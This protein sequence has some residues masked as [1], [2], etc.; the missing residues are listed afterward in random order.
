MSPTY[1]S[2]HI[3]DVVI[4]RDCEDLVHDLEVSDMISDHNLVLCRLLHKKPKPQRVTITTRKRRS[5]D[6]EIVKRHIAALAVPSDQDTSIVDYYNQSLTQILDHHAPEKTKT[7]TLHPS[8][9]WFTD[10]LH[11]AKVERRKAERTWRRTRLTVHMEIF[12][13]AKTRYNTMLDQAQHQYFNEKLT[14]CGT[15]TRAANRIMNEIMHCKREVKRPTHSCPRELP[16]IFG[17]F[18]DAKIACIRSSFPVIPHAD[19]YHVPACIPSMTNFPLAT[20][21]EI[22]RIVAKSPT[23]GCSLD[24]MPT[25]MIKAVLDPLLPLMVHAINRSLTTGTVPESMKIARVSPLLKKASLDCEVLKNYRPVS[26]LSFLS[27]I[28]EKVVASRLR[29]YMDRHKLHDPMQ[30]AYKSGHSTESALTKVQNDILCTM[31]KH[32]WLS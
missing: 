12:R 16:E 7:V 29:D 13:E 23:K 28:L 17:E 26:N 6:L 24:P 25:W 19:D 11:Q 20:E 21:K 32:A 27:K 14:D 18:F 4:T 3:L 15:D 1:R 2:G 9:P 30:S 5:V 22:K 31:D 8:Q 10:E